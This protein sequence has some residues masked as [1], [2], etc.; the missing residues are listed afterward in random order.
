[1][2]VLAAW[3]AWLRWDRLGASG[4]YL[5]DAWVAISTRVHGISDLLRIGYTSPGFILFLVRPWARVFGSSV[6]SLQLL[7][8][9]LGIIGPPLCFF[10]R[11]AGRSDLGQQCSLACS[12][13][14]RR[15]IAPIQP[16]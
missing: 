4:L 3:S 11:V 13:P 8:F 12:S 16:T 6:T 10:V 1:M 14:S 5:D 9:L 15:S 7:P 2:G